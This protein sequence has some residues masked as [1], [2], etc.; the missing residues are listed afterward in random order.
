MGHNPERVRG[1]AVALMPPKSNWR[2]RIRPGCNSRRTQVQG[3]N[4]QGVVAHM[5][6]RSLS[7]REVGGSIPPDSKHGFVGG[8]E[9]GGREEEQTL[10]REGGTGEETDRG[11]QTG[12]D[13]PGGRQ[14]GDRQGGRQGERRGTCRGRGKATTDRHVTRGGGKQ[15]EVQNS[16]KECFY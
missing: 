14:G 5:V 8:E 11:R 16:P 13:R 1:V 3:W 15:W 9:G 7:M 12:G 4:V 6:E 2:V 10:Q